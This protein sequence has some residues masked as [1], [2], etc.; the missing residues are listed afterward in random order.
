M[1]ETYKYTHGYYNVQ[2]PEMTPYANQSTLVLRGHAYKLQKHRY[3][4]NIRGNYFANRVVSIWNNLPESV[5]SAPSI[6]AFKSR[7][8]NHWKQLPTLYD[9]ECQS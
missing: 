9:P 8:D 4:L 1:I 3:K 7:L 2:Q 6:N 5:T